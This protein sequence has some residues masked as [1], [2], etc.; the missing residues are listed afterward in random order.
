MQG[1]KNRPAPG[2]VGIDVSK[3]VVDVAIWGDQPF[4]DMTI[5]QFKRTKK[6]AKDLIEWLASQPRKAAGL[7]MEWTGSLSRELAE[8]FHDIAPDLPVSLMNPCQVKAFGRSLNLRNKT[9]AVD[10]RMLAMFGHERKP[11]PWVPPTAEQDHLQSLFR[12]RAKLLEILSA[13][14]IRDGSCLNLAPLAEAA[15]TE[16][17]KLLQ[18]K[19]KA[20]EEAVSDLARQCPR[21]EADLRL[22][23]TIQ[24]VGPI[25]A[26][27]ILAEVGDLRRFRRGRQLAAFLGVSPKRYE[28]G[29]S[30]RGRTRMSRMGGT[31]VRPVLYMAAV[32][33]TQRK[34]PMGDFYRRLVAAGKPEMVAIGALMRK[35][36]L[37]MRAVLIRNKPFTV[38]EITSRDPEGRPARPEGRAAK[39]QEAGMIPKGSCPPP[40][41][42][43]ASAV[44]AW[45]FHAA[46][47]E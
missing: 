11:S 7:V 32:S 13:L 21:L 39:V 37:V 18:A 43:S 15:Q 29:S 33:I 27:A 41:L 20:L 38:P 17:I 28:S 25:T 5:A 45:T 40:G 6:G 16:V 24:G 36:V 22:L 23:Q 42:P 31:R 26:M 1:R 34:G 8:W 46:V 44:A 10:A 47:P 14:K 30:V 19:I 35:L 3:K 4:K 9:D 12:T 2:W